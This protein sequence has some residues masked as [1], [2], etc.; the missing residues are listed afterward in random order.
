M[1]ENISIASLG[2]HRLDRVLQFLSR[3]SET[4]A[5]G[6]MAKRL[7]VRMPGLEAPIEALSGGNQQKA[8]IAR[9]LST[10]ARLFL[11][12]SPTAAVDVGAKSEIYALIRGLAARGASILFTSTEMEEFPRLCS[13]VLVFHEGRI[14]G[15]LK[16]REVTEENI[17]TLAAGG[18]PAQAQE[19]S[20]HG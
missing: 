13:R 16:G 9:W 2:A 10:E 11:L 19:G 8:V 3:R 5:A 20:S 12:N 7:K 18:D 14:R 1:R 17:M 4:R 6:A 15:E